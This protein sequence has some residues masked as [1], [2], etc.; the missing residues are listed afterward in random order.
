[1]AELLR[2]LRRRPRETADFETRHRDALAG[3]AR[4]PELP[5]S[6]R[7]GAADGA[8]AGD[9]SH[10]RSRARV[11][12]VVLPV[13]HAARRRAAATSPRTAGCASPQC[14]A[15]RSKRMLADPRAETLASNFAFQW[16]R[17]RAS[18]TSSSRTAAV[19]VR[20]RRDDLRD[21]LRTETALFV[22]SVFR[23]D[24]S[25][26]DLL[27]AD[28]TFLNERLGAALRH[29][30]RARRPLPPRRARR[31][32]RA[33]ACSA[34]AACCSSRRIRI[35]RRRCCAARGCSRTSSAR[36]PRRRRRTSRRSSRT[37]KRQKREDGARA[38]RGAPHE[39]RATPATASWIRSASR[40]RTSTPSARGATKDRDAGEPIDASGELPDG[41][42]L[43]GPGRPAQGAAR[44]SPSSSCRR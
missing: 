12:A 18:S 10:H 14:C 26:L 15:R 16:L 20:L 28:H 34:R 32:P 36:R 19:P 11:A 37:S 25:V 42:Q 33:G 44:A 7:G 43:D 27:T 23:E 21:G 35:A 38:D 30:R 3:D 29:R 22:D 31:T 40:S 24:R 41:T 1:M 13:E 5:V 8:P 9:L 17:H 39:P 2:V 4:E 6:R